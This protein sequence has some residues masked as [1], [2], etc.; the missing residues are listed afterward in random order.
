MLL[1]AQIKPHFIFNTLESINALAVQNRG[2]E[3]SKMIQRLGKLLRISFV[4]NEEIPIAQE[5]EHVR[6]YLQ[7]QKHRFADAFDYDIEACEGLEHCSILK[8]ILQP[9]VENSLQHGF[10]TLEEPGRIDIKIEMQRDRVI[11]FV[12]DNG[13]GIDAAALQ[14]LEQKRALMQREDEQSEPGS[15]GTESGGMGL[16]NVAV[17]LKTHYGRP[18][19]MILCSGEGEGTTI[20]IAIPKKELPR[21]ESWE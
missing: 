19:G 18:Y 7:I 11:L 2:K 14:N 13:K 15:D 12:T 9:L 1:Q 21:A 8:L 6:Q 17:R 4:S 3:T 20:R 10:E 16:Y 5:L